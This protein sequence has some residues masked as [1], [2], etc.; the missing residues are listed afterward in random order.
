MQFWKILPALWPQER[1]H[2]S[3]QTMQQA[4][5]IITSIQGQIATIEIEGEIFPQL[6]E[7]LVASHDNSVILEVF[8]QSTDTTFVQI[9]SNP[10]KL[11]RGMPVSSTGSDLK[12]PVGPAVLGRVIDLFGNT[13]DNGGP[14]KPDKKTSIYAKTP[15]LNIVKTNYQILETGIKAIDFLTPIQKGGKVGFI[16]GAGVGK[17]ILLTELMHNVTFKQTGN[18][19]SVF[20]GV[21]ERIREGQELFQRLKQSGILPKTVILL[22][23]MNENAAIRFRVALAAAAQAE[24]FRD[25]MKSD[26]LLFVDN[27]FR[28]V[29]A[30]AEVATLLGT[31]PSEQAYQATLQTEISTFEDRLIPTES[32]TITSFQNV[33]VPAD[34]IT[35]AGVTTVVS[36]LDTSIVLSRSIAQKGIYPPI[37]LFQSSSS[38]LSKAFLG[39]VHF[40]ALTEF[41]KILENYNKLSHIVAI[42][43]EEE[44]SAENRILYNRTKKIINYLTQP[45]FMTETQTGKKGISVPKETTVNDITMILSGKLDNIPAD[46][47]MYIG[48]LAD[49]KISV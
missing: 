28:F 49:A 9:L 16:G 20:A 35:D 38:T 41:Q 48:S 34:E 2:M 17:T 24:Y 5:G 22:G 27:M 18:V 36:F 15:S 40:K 30:G 7:I 47:F 29:Q 12:I 33:Y 42:V 21:G 43:G 19:F 8:S 3:N 31:I 13:R 44:L 4:K 10:D 1:T 45:F 25:E 32:G 23:Q 6:S 26:V 37:D 14:F 46:K 39:E 11:Y